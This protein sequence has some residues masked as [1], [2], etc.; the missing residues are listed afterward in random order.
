MARKLVG[1]TATK[2][3]KI[4]GYAGPNAI[5]QLSK[6]INGVELIE[7]IE[8]KELINKRASLKIECEVCV[9]AKHTQQISLRR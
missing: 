2:W 4:L 9:L 3:Y 8:L 5:K 6:H 7:L 1:A